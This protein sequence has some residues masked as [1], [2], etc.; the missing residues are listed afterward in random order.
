MKVGIT[1]YI[2]LK[3]KNRYQVEWDL[4]QNN[5]W[6]GG[7]KAPSSLRMEENSNLRWCNWQIFLR[8]ML[9]NSLLLFEKDTPIL[10]DL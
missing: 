6:F 3:K 10:R 5:F 9:E 7:V 8:Q 1:F 2:S 4:Y